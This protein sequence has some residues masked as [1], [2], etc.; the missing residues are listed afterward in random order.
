MRFCCPY[1]LA[2]VSSY[3]VGIDEVRIFHRVLS[4]DNVRTYSRHALAG[5]ENGLILYYKFDML[6]LSDIAI[7]NIAKMQATD[8]NGMMA[9]NNAL[10]WDKAKNDD[11]Y[12]YIHLSGDLITRFEALTDESG[13]YVLAGIPF[14]NGITYSVTPTAQHGTFRYNGTSS[15]S[16]TITIGNTRPEATDVDFMNTDA[17]RLPMLMRD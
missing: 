9:A 11:D 3:G 10:I 8:G 13:N 12:R 16:A 2:P 15:A 14:A 1:S 17:A 6:S 7:P 5:D 4:Q